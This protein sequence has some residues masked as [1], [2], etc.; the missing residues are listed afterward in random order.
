MSERV[1]RK[2]RGAAKAELFCGHQASTA[3]PPYGQIGGNKLG[4]EN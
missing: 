1:Q 3:T 4:K 2:L